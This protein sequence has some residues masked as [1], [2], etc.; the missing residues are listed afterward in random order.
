MVPL[1]KPVKIA[2][3]IFLGLCAAVTLTEA[4]WGATAFLGMAGA[5]LLY[6]AYK[7]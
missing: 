7:D 5:L 2:I 3:G 6:S 1:Y 4:R